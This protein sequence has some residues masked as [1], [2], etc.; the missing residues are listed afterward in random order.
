MGRLRALIAGVRYEDSAGNDDCNGFRWGTS[1]L[2]VFVRRNRN[3]VS[4]I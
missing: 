1:N 4:V 2:L 3:P